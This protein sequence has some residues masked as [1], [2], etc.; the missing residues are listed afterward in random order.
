MAPTDP[1]SAASDAGNSTV[2]FTLVSVLL[3]S[4]F[5]LVMQVG[6]VLHTRNVL[7]ASAQEGARYGANADRGTNDARERTRE[8]VATALSPTVAGRMDYTAREVVRD[9]VLTMEVQVAGPLPLVFVPAGPLRLT[10]QG[11]ALEER[12]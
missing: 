2:E 8:S 3:V 5:L 1:G 12:R 7:V 6:F 4:L 11:H 9:G 10:V